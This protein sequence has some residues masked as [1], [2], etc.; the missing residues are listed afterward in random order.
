MAEAVVRFCEAVPSNV[1]HGISEA[2]RH[3]DAVSEDTCVV[4]ERVGASR[5]ATSCL[6][7]ATARRISLDGGSGT[8]RP[9]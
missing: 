1:V 6:M 3:R 4:P 7:S 8:S 9:A 5:C 2:R